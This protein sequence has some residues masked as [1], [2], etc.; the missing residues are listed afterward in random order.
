MTG[1][2]QQLWLEY[3]WLALPLLPLLWLLV[4]FQTRRLA[5]PP[6]TDLHSRA[7]RYIAQTANLDRIWAPTCFVFGVAFVLMGMTPNPA[8]RPP[9]PG[10]ALLGGLWLGLGLS[11]L[12]RYLHGRKVTALMM[13]EDACDGAS[14]DDAAK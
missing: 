11:S 10:H 7:K 12:V 1:S 8:G 3:W 5:E 6:L 9:S 2:I 4:F 13:T 14:S